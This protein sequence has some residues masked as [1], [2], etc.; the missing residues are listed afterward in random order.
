MSEKVYIFNEGV[1][2]HEYESV[3]HT[4]PK[5]NRNLP[6]TAYINWVSLYTNTRRTWVKKDWTVIPDSK[7]PKELK[8]ALILLGE[9]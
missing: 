1:L 5:F 4:P 6:K 2:I 3:E 9:N 7:V 8:L